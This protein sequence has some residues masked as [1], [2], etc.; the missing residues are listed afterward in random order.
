MLNPVRFASDN[1]SFSFV[2][3]FSVTIHGNDF[4]TCC[5]FSPLPN[6]YFGV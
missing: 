2:R 4:V 6:M 5:N 3:S 1:T